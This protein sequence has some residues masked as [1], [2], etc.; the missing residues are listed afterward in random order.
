MKNGRVAVLLFPLAVGPGTTT[1]LLRAVMGH[2]PV[3]AGV[4]IVA[5]SPAGRAVA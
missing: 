3:A 5:G 4:S 1:S 2:Q